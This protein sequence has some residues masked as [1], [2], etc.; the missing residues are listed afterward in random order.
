MIATIITKDKDYECIINNKYEW[1]MLI[2]DIYDWSH[3]MC[4]TEDEK[5]Y[6]RKDN[7]EEIR[8]NSKELSEL[9]KDIEEEEV[10]K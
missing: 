8:V 4:T 5:I 6:I 10:E 9:P 7:I 1:K 2:D 3:V